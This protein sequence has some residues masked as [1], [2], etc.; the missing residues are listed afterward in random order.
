MEE[1]GNG[2]Y[3]YKAVKLIIIWLTVLLFLYILVVF[4][5]MKIQH[6]PLPF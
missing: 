6:F 2:Y 5:L 3:F 4:L 1:K